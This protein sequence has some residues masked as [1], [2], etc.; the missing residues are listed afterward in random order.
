MVAMACEPNSLRL[1][2]IAPHRAVGVFHRTRKC[3]RVAQRG[4]H[5]PVPQGAAQFRQANGIVCGFHGDP[6]IVIGS[7]R[8]KIRQLYLPEDA[9]ADAAGVP[10]PAR[11]TTG[12]PIHSA[13]QVVVVP[14]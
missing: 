1:A 10:I 13:S 6:D 9:H 12:T 7:V 3:L 5:H 4:N 8:D 2:P 11:Q 14:L